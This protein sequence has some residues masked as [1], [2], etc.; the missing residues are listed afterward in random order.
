MKPNYIAKK[1]AWSCV[2]FWWILACVLV[3]PLIVLIFRIIAVKHYALEFYDDKIII[4]SGWLNTK[5]TQMVFMGVTAVSVEQSLWGKMF[6]YGNVVVDCVGKWDVNS[7]TYIC[8]PEALE[9]YLQTRI[10]P[11]GGAASIVHM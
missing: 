8:N 10:A 5:K 7:T 11:M 4:K 3:I 1:S 6:H 2:S 9:A